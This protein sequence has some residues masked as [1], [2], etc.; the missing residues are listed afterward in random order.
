MRASE[1]GEQPSG[2]YGPAVAILVAGLAGLAMFAAFPP[3]EIGALA[4]VALFLFFFALGQCPGPGWAALVGLVY[5][6]CFFL[7][8][9]GYICAF[10]VVPWLL[11]GLWEAAGLAALGLLGWQVSQGQRPGWKIAGLAALWVLLEYGRGHRGPLSL[12]LGDVY[13]SQWDQPALVQLASL[14]GG[15]LISFLM[16]GLC[17]ALAVTARAWVPGRWRRPPGWGP[18]YARDAA[19]ALLTVYTMF[20]LAFFWGVWV[21][22]RGRRML[23]SLA[24][25]RGVRVG[26]VQASVARHHVLQPGEAE[27]SAESY[28]ALSE[29]LPPGL[30]L[31]VW[32]ETA[33]PVVLARHTDYQARLKALARQLQAW[34]LVGANEEAPGGRL[35]NTLF[36]FDPQGR[37]AGFY[38]K[39]HLVLF[40]EYVPGR[41]RFPFLQ[42]FPIRPFDYAPGADFTVLRAGQ[43]SFGPLICFEALFPEYA[44]LLCQRGAEFLVIATSD[45]WA[46]GSYELRQHSRTA[47]FRAVE[48]RRFVLRVA[49]HGE[50]ALITPWGERLAVLQVGERGVQHEVLFPVQGLSLYHRWGDGPLLGLCLVLWVGAAAGARRPAARAAGQGGLGGRP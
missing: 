21:Y 10:G 25:A 14:G 33:L 4:W 36:L 24:P 7:P 48:A 44:R 34:L 49:D 41:K 11:L 3:A 1:G 13:Y 31:V 26:Y 42:R 29:L 43:V 23:A 18:E 45:A 50:S 27:R 19:R 16:A 5:G 39:V 28:F 37:V 46:A 22:G 20:F 12:T 38:R 40:G 47:V 2:G 8:L 15:H 35:Y 9:L 30:Q 6:L 17:A 32:P